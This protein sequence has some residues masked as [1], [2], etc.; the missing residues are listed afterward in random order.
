MMRDMAGYENSSM[1][2]ATRDDATVLISEDINTRVV[3][4][5]P[6]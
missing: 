2:E 6:T 4:L 3:A 5:M 1:S